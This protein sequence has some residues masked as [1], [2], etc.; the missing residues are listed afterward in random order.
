MNEQKILDKD[1][2]DSD[3]GTDEQDSDFATDARINERKMQ[4][5]DG[6]D[7]DFGTDARINERKTQ[8]FAPK[9]LECNSGLQ[10]ECDILFWVT[11]AS[12]AP[13]LQTAGLA[14]DASGFILVNDKL[15]SISHPQVFAA[16][17]VATMVNHSRP[18]AGVFAVR[19]GKPLLENLQRAL[20]KKPLK[21]FIPQKKFLILIGTGDQR[22]IASRGKMGFGPESLLWRWKDNIDRKFMDKFTNLKMEGRSYPSSGKGKRRKKKD[23][24]I[25]HCAGC[26]AK[27]GSKV[28]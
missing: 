23:S 17:D 1:G 7:S 24:E 15:Q 18:K 12:A 20:Q 14:T 3:F 8:D 28:L 13:W 9:I 2:Q 16:G 10:I 27:V 22:A 21:S 6:Q 26:G 19:Q 4:D 5:K 11:Q 25:M